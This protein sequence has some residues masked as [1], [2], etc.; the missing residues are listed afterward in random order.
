MT[1]KKLKK[2]LGRIHVPDKRDKNFPVMSALPKN[3]SGR[4][5]KYWWD[6]A[7][8]GDQAATPQ[9][10]AYA[11]MH[12]LED[13]PV[14]HFYEDRDFDPSYLNEKAKE[15]HQ[16]L[17]KPQKIYESA[18]KVDR[19]PGQDYDGTSVRAGAKILKELG[20]ISEYR[21]AFTIVDVIQT[22]LELGPM[23]VGTWWHRDMFYPDKEGFI[24]P[25]GEKMGGH[26]YVLNG[27]NTEKD[28]LRIKNSW[29]RQWGDSGHAYI[30]INDFQKLLQ[31]YGEACIAFEKKLKK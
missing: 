17:F 27:I 29:G 24:T 30:K 26:A 7:W 23:V 15:K 12:W 2:K 28:V 31:D 20:V 19:W 13:G 1:D 11:W 5:Y 22:L 10:V 9:C 25:T 21:W 14:T 16:S 8:W 4:V 6:Q 3:R 18:Q